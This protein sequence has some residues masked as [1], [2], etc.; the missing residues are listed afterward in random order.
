MALNHYLNAMGPMEIYQHIQF[1]SEE[2]ADSVFEA[3]DGSSADI[4]VGDGAVPLRFYDYLQVEAMEAIDDIELAYT[5]LI[6]KMGIISEAVEYG[7]DQTTEAFGLYHFVIYISC[8]LRRANH[9]DLLDRHN[10]TIAQILKRFSNMVM[11]ATEPLPQSGNII[12]HAS[13]NRMTMETE[14]AGLIAEIQALLTLNREIKA[15]W[16]RGPLH[17]PGED[18]AREAAMDAQAENVAQLYD[19]VLEVRDRAVNRIDNLLVREQAMHAANAADVGARSAAV[20]GTFMGGGLG[21]G[22]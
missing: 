7:V 19:R 17:Q 2:L 9:L 11:A 15:L 14:C 18:A 22:S 16:I 4:M 12:E 20:G 1:K 13:I 3:L 5:Y 10:R 8:K 6:V 21:G